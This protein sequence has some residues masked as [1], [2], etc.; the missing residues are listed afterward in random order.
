MKYRNI[1][2]VDDDADDVEIFLMATKLVDE[3]I[4]CRVESNAL[5]A[6]RKLKEG[7]RLPKIIFLDYHMPYLDG[8]EFLNLI[9]NIESLKEIPVVLYSGHSGD[10]VKKAIKKFKNVRF[11]KKQSSFSDII[12]SV[13]EILNL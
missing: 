10:A 11:L 6:F 12:E 1:L 3:K 7:K 5:D 2:L 4:T 13:R 9:R 8:R